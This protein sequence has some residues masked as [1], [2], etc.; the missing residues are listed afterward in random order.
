MALD[1]QGLIRRNDL[2]WFIRS[3]W[4]RKWLLFFPIA[5]VAV[6]FT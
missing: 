2:Y 5:I 1:I 3:Q 4:K 6:L